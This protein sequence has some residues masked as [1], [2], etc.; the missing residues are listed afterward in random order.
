MPNVL[1]NVLQTSG[2]NGQQPWR[3]YYQGIKPQNPLGKVVRR[4]GNK[5]K[6]VVPATTT[7]TM[8][9]SYMTNTISN[10]EGYIPPYKPLS[11]RYVQQYSS[12]E[13]S[14][15]TYRNNDSIGSVY[16]NEP[17][18]QSSAYSYD[19]RQPNYYKNSREMERSAR[20]QRREARRAVADVRANYRS[21]LDTAREARGWSTTL[22]VV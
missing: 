12:P 21:L 18:Y 7:K 1:Q 3:Q 9:F 2:L 6:N 14:S 22:G 20:E 5:V 10:F 11:T 17:Y 19:Y 13:L 16:T 8:Q 15:M 4:M